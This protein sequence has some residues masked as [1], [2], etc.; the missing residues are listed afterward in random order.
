MLKKGELDEFELTSRQWQMQT[1]DDEFYKTTVKVRGDEWTYG[2]VVWNCT[3]PFFQDKRVRKAIALAFDM[4]ELLKKV[5][6]GL[7]PQCGGPENPDSPWGTP[8]VKLIQQDVDAA[9]K[10][11]D[12]AGWKLGADGVRAKDG[13]RFEFTLNVPQGGTGV[14]VAEV[15]QQNLKDIGIVMNVKMLEWATYADKT[16]SH[17]FDAGVQAWGTGTDPD[18]GKNVWKTEMYKE[19]RNYGGYSNPKVDELFEKGSKEFDFEAR[20]KIY[21]EINRLIYDDQPYLFLNYRCTFWGFSKDC[22]GYNMSPR[23]PMGYSPGFSQIW[24]PKKKTS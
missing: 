22:R 6:F 14:K 18:L 4:N 12:E 20:R 10:L 13:K 24:K 2:C 15:L 19:G 17:D 23:D 11:L 5:Y 7:Y 16:Q 8:D 3:R 9:E 21:Q 1:T